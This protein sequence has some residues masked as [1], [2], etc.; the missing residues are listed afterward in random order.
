MRPGAYK[1]SK[2][3]AAQ[4]GF[5]SCIPKQIVCVKG[6]PEASPRMGRALLVNHT[7]KGGHHSPD[8]R[9]RMGWLVRRRERNVRVL[10]ACESGSRAWGFRLLT[11]IMTFDLYAH[12]KQWYLGL[13]IGVMSSKS[14]LAMH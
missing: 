4:S 14:P 13:E 8:M 2:V 3:M 7:G 9:R 11:V 5:E 6:D 1:T 12:P 10:F